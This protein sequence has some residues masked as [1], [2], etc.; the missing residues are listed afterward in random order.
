MFSNV[1]FKIIQRTKVKNDH[2]KILALKLTPLGQRP[3][4]YFVGPLEGP[5]VTKLF[6]SYTMNN[7]QM[8]GVY[9]GFYFHPDLVGLFLVPSSFSITL[10]SFAD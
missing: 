3:D 9:S 10:F 4:A 5:G 8:N 6:D 7:V 2:S 1:A